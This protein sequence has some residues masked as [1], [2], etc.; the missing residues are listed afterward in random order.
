MVFAQEDMEIRMKRLVN[1]QQIF[2]R[3]IDF[4]E[5]IEIVRS[6]SHLNVA[7]LSSEIMHESLFNLLSYGIK[8]T[9]QIRRVS[10]DW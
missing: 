9:K 3:I 7:D 8:K 1:Q 6:I 10:F 5:S 4:K 2:G